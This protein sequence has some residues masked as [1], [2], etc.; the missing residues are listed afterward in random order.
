MSK[1]RQACK[2]RM[3]YRRLHV[4]KPQV[5]T[6][7][8]CCIEVSHSKEEEWNNTGPGNS[9]AALKSYQSVA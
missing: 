5:T 1:V 9:S 2:N 3:S 8:L 7:N 6:G 4:H